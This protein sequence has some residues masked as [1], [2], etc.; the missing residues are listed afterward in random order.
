MGCGIIFVF[1]ALLL[2]A[3]LVLTRDVLV[4][5]LFVLSCIETIFY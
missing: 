1:G 2:E 3:D 4:F 5:L